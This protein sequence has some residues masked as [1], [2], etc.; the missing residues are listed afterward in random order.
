MRTGEGRREE[1]KV[2]IIVDGKVYA[3]RAL[4]LP[5]EF[6]MTRTLNAKLPE[7]FAVSVCRFSFV[8]TSHI[9]IGLIS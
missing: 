1:T 8:R 7:H 2:V 3:G 4:F 9:E 5:D 6:R